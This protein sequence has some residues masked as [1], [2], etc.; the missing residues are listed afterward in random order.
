MGISLSL[1]SL[2]LFLEIRAFYSMPAYTLAYRVGIRGI[3]TALLKGA[4]M[5]AVLLDIV[6]GLMC[7]LTW[8]AS[9]V[10][11]SS[12]HLPAFIG[13]KPSCPNKKLIPKKV[14]FRDLSTVLTQSFSKFEVYKNPLE[15]LFKNRYGCR[16]GL[17]PR[18]IFQ[19]GPRRVIGGHRRKKF[20]EQSQ[21][22]KFNFL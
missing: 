17:G 9:T 2:T 3:F 1:H 14:H 11:A 21:E 22:R 20:R 5:G 16:S 13:F 10:L 12:T 4:P 19:P 6:L 18:F 8:E 7:N 15:I